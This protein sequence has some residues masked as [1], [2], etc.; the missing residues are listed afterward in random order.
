MSH[1]DDLA[2]I[3]IQEQRLRLSTFDDETAWALGSWLRSTARTRGLAIAADIHVNGMSHFAVALPGARPDNAEWIRRKRNLV[4][5]TFN[6]SYTSELKLK[7]AETTLE[8]RSGLSPRDF[9][10]AGGSFP[11]V[12][13]GA[14]TIG[15]LTV[16]GLTGRQDHLLVVEA[17]AMHLGIPFT[18]VAMAEG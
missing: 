16:S 14:G 17:L 18:E 10:A 3:A 12:V 8:A 1:H 15:A 9:A 11:I 6:S 2:C 7:I 13:S 5:R 4:L